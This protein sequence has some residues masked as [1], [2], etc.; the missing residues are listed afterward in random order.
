[1][2]QIDIKKEQECRLKKHLIREK[3]IEITIVHT[4]ARS[5]VEQLEREIKAL[6]GGLD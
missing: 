4:K 6:E 3:E 5:K 1:M 2:K